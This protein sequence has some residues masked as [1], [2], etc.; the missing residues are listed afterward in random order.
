MIHQSRLV[1]NSE[2]SH[3]HMTAAKFAELESVTEA[4]LITPSHSS[5]ADKTARL[6]CGSYVETATLKRPRPT[7]LS[8]PVRLRDKSAWPDLKRSVGASGAGVDL[9][10]L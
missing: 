1:P 9:T 10:A 5:M 4:K 6:I 2:L 3:A 7:W 8:S